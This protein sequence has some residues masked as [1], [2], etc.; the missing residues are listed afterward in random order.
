[1]NSELERM[2]WGTTQGFPVGAQENHEIP[3][4]Q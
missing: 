4:S 2:S 3:Q 1:M